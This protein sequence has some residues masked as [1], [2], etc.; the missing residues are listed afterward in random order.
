MG[1]MCGC[2]FCREFGFRAFGLLGGVCVSVCVCVIVCGSMGWVVCF[3]RSLLLRLG[4]ELGFCEL[5]AGFWAVCM[6]LVF[7]FNLWAFLGA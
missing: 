1:I 5:L 4:F 6:T 2:L 3:I 7:V